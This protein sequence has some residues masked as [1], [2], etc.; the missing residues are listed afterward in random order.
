MAICLKKI[1]PSGQHPAGSKQ[2]HN[3]PQGQSKRS[4]RQAQRLTDKSIEQLI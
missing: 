1:N 4:V 3:A 2:A